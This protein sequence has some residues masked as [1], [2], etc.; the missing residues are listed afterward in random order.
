MS[1]AETETDPKAPV[2]ADLVA[3]QCGQCGGSVPVADLESATC[4]YCGQLV[5]VPEEHRNAVRLVRAQ[6]TELRHAEREWSRFTRTTLPTW[7]ATLFAMPP[8]LILAGSLTAALLAKLGLLVLSSEPRIFFA[9][10]GLLPL[11]PAVVLAVVAYWSSTTAEGIRLTRVLL[12]ARPGKVPTCRNCGAPLLVPEQALFVRCPYCRTDS[13]VTLDALQARALL[14]NID[15][16]EASAQGAIESARARRA[17]ALW[18]ARWMAAIW[19]GMISIALL[20]AFVPTLDAVIGLVAADV[21]VLSLFTY[22][23]T[24]GTLVSSVGSPRL[25]AK[26]SAVGAAAG[27]ALATASTVALWLIA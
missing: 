16:A 15:R 6:D 11:A 18:A 14:E 4:P 21:F 7:L 19:F 22:L 9:I 13:L 8:S 2:A 23:I 5:S 10:S 3:L 26:L 1:V 24:A 27:F 25:R 12:A 20:W 17:K